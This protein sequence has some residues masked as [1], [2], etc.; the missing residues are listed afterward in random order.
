MMPVAWSRVYK[1]EADKENKVLCTTMGAA[2]DLTNEGL[3]RMIVNAVYWGL[4]LEVPKKARVD[5]VDDFKPTMYGFGG[6]RR[7]IKPSDHAL[8]KVLPPGETKKT[9]N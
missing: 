6:F 2:S 3:R 7:G 1:N 9:P 5:Y 8:G 4:D